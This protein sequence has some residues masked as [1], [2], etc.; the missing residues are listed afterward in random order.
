MKEM[1]PLNGKTEL[2]IWLGDSEKEYVIS[3][4]PESK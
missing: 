2:I 3:D 4:L 1:D